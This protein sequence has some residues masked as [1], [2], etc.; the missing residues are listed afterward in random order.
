MYREWPRLVALY[1]VDVVL[2]RLRDFWLLPFSHPHNQGWPL[3]LLLGSA[4]L[5]GNQTLDEPGPM[6]FIGLD[7]LIQKHLAHLRDGSL[8]PIRELLQPSF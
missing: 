7:T 8:F 5:L 4:L 2:I 6:F 1:R 3:R